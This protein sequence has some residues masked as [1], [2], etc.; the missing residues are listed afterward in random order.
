VLAVY[1]FGDHG[2][3]PYFVMEH[4][5]AALVAFRKKPDRS[6]SSFGARSGRVAWDRC[7]NRRES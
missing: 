3:T 1:A 7:G 6:C 5:D 4:V 2:A